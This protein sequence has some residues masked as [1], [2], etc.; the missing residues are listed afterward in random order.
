M[1]II[2]NAVVLT[3]WLSTGV[4]QA[5]T[6]TCAPTAGQVAEVTPGGSGLDFSPEVPLPNFA[7]GPVTPTFIAEY[8]RAVFVYFIWAVGI[9]ATAMIVFGGIKWVAAAGNPGRINDARETIN[10]ALI[11]LVIAL[12][13]VLLLQTINPSLTSF[14]GISLKPVDKCLI[15]MLSDVVKETGTVSETRCPE[16]LK[17]AG[18]EPSQA[19]TTSTCKD[20]YNDWVNDA[21]KKYT[22]NGDT[23]PILIKAV[24]EVE[25]YANAKGYPIS[26]ATKLPESKGSTLLG[27]G[28]GLGQMVYLTLA[29]QLRKVKGSIPDKCKFPSLADAREPNGSLKQDCAN[30]LDQNLKLQVELVASYLQEVSNGRCVKGNPTFIAAAYHLGQGGVED[31]CQGKTLQDTTREAVVQ[32]L[33]AFNQEYYKICA[34][35]P[36]RVTSK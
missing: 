13:S 7:G 21:A 33:N 19:C 6:T 8:I 28:Y 26:E 16:F 17:K 20:G 27:S 25:T 12:T 15:T 34:A 5:Q 9:L 35:S 1:G 10:N 29:D 11:G 22:V 14:R 36:D 30:Y 18:G 31:Y 2:L 3:A 24:I 23:R 4:A 32:Y